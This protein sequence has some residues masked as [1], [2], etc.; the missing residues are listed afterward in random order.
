M[1]KASTIVLCA[2]LTAVTLPAAATGKKNIP[3]R[4]VVH[5]H[6]GYLV[7]A[8]I[9][10]GITY[11]IMRRKAKRHGLTR[12]CPIVQCPVM[13]TCETQTERVLQ[14]CVAK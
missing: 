1:V 3:E 12:E 4:Q 5:D 7:G 2:A 13:P 6:D 10:A 14:S 11:W 9:G 8:L